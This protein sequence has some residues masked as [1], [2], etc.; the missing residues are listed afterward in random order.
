[1]TCNKALFYK[2]P[3]VVLTLLTRKE[4]K[5]L[6]FS[7]LYWQ[8]LLFSLSFFMVV[9]CY[10]ITGTVTVEVD[11]GHQTVKTRASGSTEVIGTNTAEYGITAT[12]DPKPGPNEEVKA[13][14]PS[15]SITSSV[16]FLPPQGIIPVPTNPGDPSVNISGS[17]G[18][19]IAKVHTPNVGQ[20]K[21]TF[22]AKVVYKL[23]NSVTNKYIYN[24]DGTVKT[25]E[26]TGTGNCRFK[27]TLGNF[28]IVLLP[29]DNF[30]GRS[31]SSLGVGETGTGGSS[32]DNSGKIYV[33]PI[34]STPQSDIFPLQSFSSSDTTAFSM[35]ANYEDGTATF[36]AGGVKGN[37][38]VT[39]TDKNGN[40]ETYQIEILQPQGIRMEVQKKMTIHPI[41]LV[42]EYKNSFHNTAFR[43]RLCLVTYIDPK[44]VSFFKIKAYEGYARY[45]RKDDDIEYCR[46]NGFPSEHPEWSNKPGV[47][48]GDISKGCHV[49]GPNPADASS[50]NPLPYDASGSL[51]PDTKA[52]GWNAGYGPGTTTIE[53]PWKYDVVG[54]TTG[55][56]IQKVNSNME[57]DGTKAHIT[58]QNEVGVFD[59]FPV[60]K[61]AQ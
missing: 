57:F 52:S 5:M 59:Y 9:S 38:V 25:Q 11:P 32:P 47:S 60:V 37:T 54:N 15:W 42:T 21:I 44:E 10:A 50:G 45:T 48:R 14:E 26:F 58:K 7:K 36:T 40:S 16:T 55:Q 1:M 22:T 43:V 2:I 24:P 46:K 13:V 3:N 4:I 56:E 30:S 27:S 31:L 23:K 28:R 34:G 19:W 61:V 18:N 33:E 29:D 20:W 6:K 41:A 17:G 49:L 35:E 39:A 53:L 12:C 8:V 51:R